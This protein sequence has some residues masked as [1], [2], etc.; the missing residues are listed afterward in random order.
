MCRLFIEEG[1]RSGGVTMENTERP[2]VD[3][4]DLSEAVL[5]LFE[6]P[7]SEGRYICSAYSFRTKEFVEKMETMFPGY[8]YPKM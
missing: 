5:L 4:R 1:R 8:N 3:V 2:Y 7:K 6:N